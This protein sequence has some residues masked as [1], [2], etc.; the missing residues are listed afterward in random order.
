LYISQDIYVPVGFDFAQGIKFPQGLGD[1]EYDP[2]SGTPPDGSGS[3]PDDFFSQ[4]CIA[5]AD[6]K[7]AC[8]C[9]HYG[10]AGPYGTVFKWYHG[11]TGL[12][13]DRCVLTP[14]QWHRLEV[15][16]K[17][18]TAAGTADGKLHAWLNGEKVLNQNSLIWTNTGTF[19]IGTLRFSTFYSPSYPSVNQYVYYDNFIVSKTPIT[20]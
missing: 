9:Y 16:L 12:E 6:G 15:Y 13:A 19:K 8:Y 11:L 2:T 4:R 18:N 10:M 14:G 5:Q 20:H 17:L 3:S 7:L 1:V